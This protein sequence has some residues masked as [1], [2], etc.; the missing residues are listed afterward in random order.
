MTHDFQHIDRIDAYLNDV[1]SEAERAKF[2]QELANDPALRQEF[3]LVQDILG[4]VELAGDEALKA[5]IGAAHHE[6]ATEG[7]FAKPEAKIVEMKPAQWG[8]RRVLAVAASVLLLVAAGVWWWSNSQGDAGQRII[9]QYYAAETTKLATA[10]DDTSAPG[11]GQDDRP[12]RSSLAAALKLYQSRSFGEAEKALETHL[13][14]YPQ[15]TISQFYLALS[16]LEL[17]HFE[18]ATALLRPITPTTLTPDARPGQASQVLDFQY[19]ITWY[20][21][22]ASSQLPGQ[23]NL[24]STLLLLRKLEV[25][26][27]GEWSAKAREVLGKIEKLGN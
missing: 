26:G 18:Q 27:N 19:E 15:D 16:H 6:L 22:L 23:V 13:Q 7:F 14:T 4:G 24:D 3:D 1:L 17:G 11:L 25:S 5:Q 8:M 2:E 21:A 10:I 12:R 9:Q 20:L